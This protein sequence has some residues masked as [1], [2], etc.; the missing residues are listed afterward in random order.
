MK[1]RICWTRGWTLMPLALLAACGGAP[2]EN[3]A[4]DPANA[5]VPPGPMLGGVDLSTPLQIR[6]VEGRDWALDLAPGRILFQQE[7][8]KQVPFYPVSPRLAQ[9]AAT[10]P[11]QTP[12]GAAVTITLRPAACAEGAN[13]AADVRIGANI[14]KGCA[15]PM[16]VEQVHREMYNEALAVPYDG[17]N[18]SSAD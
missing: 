13:L 11:T 15:H 12:E 1:P 6:P 18:N 10:Y 7:G 5:A 9:G 2:T 8:A 16:T 14:L 3:A 17:G 4:E